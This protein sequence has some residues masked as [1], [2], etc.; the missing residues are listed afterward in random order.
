MP[1]TINMYVNFEINIYF[2]LYSKQNFVVASQC[3]INLALNILVMSVLFSLGILPLLSCL[4][5]M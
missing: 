3:T 5:C 1:V 2:R 4:S